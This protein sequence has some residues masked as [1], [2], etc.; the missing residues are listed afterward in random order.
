MIDKRTIDK[1]QG[2]ISEIEGFRFCGPSYDPDE[3][4]AVVYGFSHLLRT[5]K[6]YGMRIDSGFQ[7]LA[8]SW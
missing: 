1:L 4:T 8:S 2:I 3:Q 6:Y 7:N 5:F